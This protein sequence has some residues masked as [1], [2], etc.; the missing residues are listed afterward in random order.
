MDINSDQYWMAK[1]LLLAQQ[2]LGRTGRNP[3]VA[4]ILVKDNHIIAQARTGD[5]G[6]PHAEEDALRLAGDKAQGCTA[7]LTFEPCAHPGT[8]EGGCAALL[9]NAAI[10]RIVYACPDPDPRTSGKGAAY[11]QGHGVAVTTNI[12]RDEAEDLNRGFIRRMCDQRPYVGMKIATSLDGMMACANGQSQWITGQAA[13]DQGHRIR[14][15]YDSILTGSGTW[16]ADQPQLTVRLPDYDGPQ[17][18]RFVLDRRGRVN[19]SAAT[20]L[21]QNTAD[22]A[23]KAMAVDH[24]VNRVLIEA[25]AQLSAA[26]LQAGLVDELYWFRAPIMMG[27]DGLSP[28]PSMALTHVDQA[29]PWRRLSSVLLGL[30]VLDVYA[31]DASDNCV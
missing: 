15:T 6:R 17:P 12:C 2:G 29:L 9:T 8:R 21:D 22:E 24:K 25:G 26:F 4:C 13:R 14:A 28:F 31:C 5:G 27:A 3:S 23:L 30:D 10:A 7:Y 16:L 1:A 18:H 20:R 11:C 19:D